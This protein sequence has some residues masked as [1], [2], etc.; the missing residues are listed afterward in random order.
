M[1]HDLEALSGREFPMYRRVAEYHGKT[2]AMPFLSA[3][4]TDFAG[5]LAT[6]ELFTEGMNKAVLRVA[7]S[8]LGVP[9][10]M[11]A[12]PKKAMQYGSGVS[13]SLRSVLK[14]EGMGLRE[15]MLSME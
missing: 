6:E 3:A 1:S 14:R 12:R 7:A 10:R 8:S 15:L 13:A 2:L 4:V 9:D 11:A 5:G